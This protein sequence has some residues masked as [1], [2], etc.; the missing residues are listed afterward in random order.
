MATSA[1][2]WASTPLPKASRRPSGVRR[3]MAVSDSPGF[4]MSASS[5]QSRS[6][7]NH[8]AWMVVFTLLPL[9]QPIGNACSGRASDTGSA[10]PLPLREVAGFSRPA[11]SMPP[12]SSIQPSRH[13]AFSACSCSL[14]CC[15]ASPM[16]SAGERPS[17]DNASRSDSRLC[18]SFCSASGSAH[19]PCST[20]A[21]SSGRP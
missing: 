17:P 15:C 16:A 5:T 2:S 4:A 19:Q 3:F 18:T 9:S 1:G 20:R 10:P 21:A 8:W 14:R 7:C 12:S 6:S 13:G 11:S